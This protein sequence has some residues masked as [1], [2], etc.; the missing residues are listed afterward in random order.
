[1]PAAHRGSASE[2]GSPRFSS[3][4]PKIAPKRRE[5]LFTH[6]RKRCNPIRVAATAMI[7]LFGFQFLHANWVFG[8]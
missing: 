7:G 4:T 1:M 3:G 8:K 2:R 5:I 6:D